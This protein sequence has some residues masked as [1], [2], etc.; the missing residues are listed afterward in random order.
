M[1]TTT[2][3]RTTTA[4]Q[5]ISVPNRS[6]KPTARPNIPLPPK[7]IRPPLRPRTTTSKTRFPNFEPS[8]ETTTPASFQ[9]P[10]T[11]VTTSI[12]I[13]TTTT[14]ITSRVPRTTTT[15]L[16]IPPSAAPTLSSSPPP[17][18]SR[19]SH[20]T[21]A[22]SFQTTRSRFSH[23]KTSNENPQ[24]RHRQ[25]YHRQ[26][27]RDQESVEAPREKNL[28][29][30][31]VHERPSQT[32]STTSPKRLRSRHRFRGGADRTEEK[33][34]EEV[35]QPSRT[36]PQQRPPR[37]ES[38]S[39]RPVVE[40]VRE[41]V[42]KFVKPTLP[43][44]SSRMT[45]F[46]AFRNFPQFPR[47]DKKEVSP[48]PHRN[49]A[50][51][52]RDGHIQ[53]VPPESAPQ[54][55]FAQFVK[56]EP[57]DEVPSQPPFQRNFAHFSRDEHKQEVPSPSSVSQRNFGQFSRDEQTLEVPQP[58]APQQNFAQFSRDEHNQEI[59]TP[60][61]TPERNFA[62]FSR[63]EHNQ[64]VPPPSDAP[65]RNFAQFSRDEHNQE[66]LPLSSAPTQNFAQF[67]GDET[68]KEVP[69]PSA[70][71][72][73]FAQ[74]SRVEEE[75]PR[76]IPPKRNFQSFQSAPSAFTAIPHLP[77]DVTVNRPNNVQQPQLLHTGKHQGFDV[78]STVV[79]DP[80]SQSTSFFNI[81]RPQFQHSP[82]LDQPPRGFSSNP[83]FQTRPS[84]VEQPR[85]FGPFPSETTNQGFFTFLA[86]EPNIGFRRE[87]S[88]RSFRTER[89]SQFEFPE[90]EFGGFV[91]VNGGV[92][93]KRNPNSGGLSS[94]HV[95]PRLGQD[96]SSEGLHSIL[97]RA[98][99]QMFS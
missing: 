53:E 72:R 52:S 81:Q 98:L 48:P 8:V 18:R 85:S 14:R 58:F 50:Q 61:S 43:P 94:T 75:H 41:E 65:E 79:H 77:V 69:H 99:S 84:P 88:G 12:P 20:R 21:K 38:T 22:P 87:G 68:E 2:T 63:E 36:T 46:T 91:P 45:P 66:V 39:P 97:K 37:I 26:R 24:L 62:Q 54:R 30:R 74:F 93:D 95:S 78:S 89:D 55:N 82:P 29:Q 16:S 51:F 71:H 27:I 32:L 4:P 5:T 3:T 86:D 13:T 1:S 92:R 59:H 42:P 19:F 7:T 28:R 47:G 49:F 44:Q 34:Q 80:N 60:L 76:E 90:A 33:N 73:N 6:S 31:V 23:Q 64:E 67:S 57:T 83:R 40:E 15:T 25:T 9:R 35:G 96:P 10:T 11:I 17:T 56:N 70:P